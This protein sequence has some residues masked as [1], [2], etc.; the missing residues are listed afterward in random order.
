MHD[1]KFIRENPK[2]FDTFMKRRGLKPISNEILEL[3]KER[4]DML[5]KLQIKQSERNRISKEIRSSETTCARLLFE[6]YRL[7]RI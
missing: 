7:F 1:I 2:M 5:T 3:D 6:N 4:R